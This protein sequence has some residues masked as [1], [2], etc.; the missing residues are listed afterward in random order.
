MIERIPERRVLD[1]HAIMALLEDEPGAERVTEVLKS[2]EPWMTL[3]NL[4]EITYTIERRRGKQEADTV[5]AN[6]LADE[7]PGGAGP[8]QWLPVDRT[9]VR[10]A[11]ELKAVGGMS[12]A[13]C[14]AAAAAVLLQCPLLTG[15]PEFSAA[16]HAGVE[17]EWL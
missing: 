4:G 6:L 13:D 17:I 1:A 12:Y 11:A 2:G 15:D 10:R 14:F 3:V 9:L 8:I 7:W 5:F 16:E